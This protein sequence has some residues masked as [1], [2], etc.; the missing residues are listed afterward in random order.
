LL[1]SQPCAYGQSVKETH[2]QSFER[3]SGSSATAKNALD[4]ERVKDEILSMTNQLRREQGQREL[5][6]NED[7]AKAA[8]YFAEYMARTDKYSH[9]ADGKEPWERA[10]KF[11]YA[12]CI[13][14]ENIAY[15]FNPEGFRTADLARGFMEG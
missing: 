6:V 11:D 10:S 1:L 2:S 15:E 8:Q 14:L 3:A 5:K 7:L 12:Y 4:L 9:T 13:I